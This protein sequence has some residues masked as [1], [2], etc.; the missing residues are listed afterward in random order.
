MAGKEMVK[1]T[2]MAMEGAVGCQCWQQQEG[3]DMVSMGR[4]Y[5]FNH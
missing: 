5:Q 2:G 1:E 3:P 4:A